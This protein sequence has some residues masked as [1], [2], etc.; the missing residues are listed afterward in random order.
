MPKIDFKKCLDLAGVER[1]FP[2]QRRLALDEIEGS[3]VFEGKVGSACRG[4]GVT[5]T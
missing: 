2:K 1:E 3:F 5:C 4:I